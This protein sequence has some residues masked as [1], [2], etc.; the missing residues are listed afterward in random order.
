VSPS[1]TATK[2]EHAMD[3]PDEPPDDDERSV[4]DASVTLDVTLAPVVVFSEVD[5]DAMLGSC[6]EIV[7]HVVLRDDDADDGAP[8]SGVRRCERRDP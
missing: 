3:T 1:C 8:R 7:L 6:N 4:S 2:K 5:F